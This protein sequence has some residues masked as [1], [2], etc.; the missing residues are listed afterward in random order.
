MARRNFLRRIWDA[1]R[2]PESYAP[3]P[4][5]TPVEPPPPSFSP[6]PF[7]RTQFI[8]TADLPSEWSRAEK[9]LWQDATKT[10]DRLAHDEIAQAYYNAALF[11]RSI[12]TEE[13]NDYREQFKQY[14]FRTYGIVWDDIFDW[15]EWRD[16]VS[17]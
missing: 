4:L 10:N 9:G 11:T 2:N 6:P 3:P 12:P 14:V 1:I 7:Q 8:S 16:L 17:P 5:P 13:K 15:R